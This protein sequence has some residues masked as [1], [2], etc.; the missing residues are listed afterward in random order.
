M[1]LFRCSASSR[2]SSV[3]HNSTEEFSSFIVSPCCLVQS[4]ERERSPPTP[5]LPSGGQE[6]VVDT[7]PHKGECRSHRIKR[8]VGESLSKS[9][10]SVGER[11]RCL[12]E[13]A[14]AEKNRSVDDPQQRAAALGF[15][16]DA[17]DVEQK[18]NSGGRRGGFQT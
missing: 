14:P 10:E 9:G 1:D 2:L 6:L 5:P 18:I 16:W 13:R 12:R 7:L 8:R 15:E 17:K 11:G 4:L 3:E